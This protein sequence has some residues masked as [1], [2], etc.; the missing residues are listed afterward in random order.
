[1][2][3]ISFCSA[4]RALRSASTCQLSVFASRS[5]HVHPAPLAPGPRQSCFPEEPL[6][7]PAVH[8]DLFRM[9]D[10][11]KEAR[12][13]ICRSLLKLNLELRGG[14]PR[15]SWLQQSAPSCTDL[16]AAHGTQGRRA[17][18]RQLGFDLAALCTFM[19]YCPMD[20]TGTELGQ[21]API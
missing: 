20:G 15:P 21:C 13:Q 14:T 16:I 6:L 5:P 19:L 4:S 9:A 8:L 12:S 3:A 17:E 7:P 2:D 10:T 1:M 11:N 18:S